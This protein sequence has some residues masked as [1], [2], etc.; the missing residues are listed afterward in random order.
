M[1]LRDRR[2]SLSVPSD[3]VAHMF[4]TDLRDA[5]AKAAVAAVGVLSDSELMAAMLDIETA[6]RHLDASRA[7][8]LHRLEATEATVT[9]Q[10]LRTASWVTHHRHQDARG[11]R[12]RVRASRHLCQHLPD[13]VEALAQAELSWDH[14]LVL[15]RAAN[16][17]IAGQVNELL[18]ELITLAQHLPFDIW[19]RE[20]AA[21]AEHLDADGAHQPVVPANRVRLTDGFD[22]SANLDGEF[23]DDAA[24]ELRALLD[25]QTDRIWRRYKQLSEVDGDANVIPPRNQ[26][27]AEALLE[28]VRLGSA[29]DA[30]ATRPTR[31]DVTVV[32]QPNG[33]ATTLSGSPLRSYHVEALLRRALFHAVHADGDGCVHGPSQ[34]IDSIDPNTEFGRVI[35]AALGEAEPTDLD[36]G[37]RFAN[38]AVRRAVASRDGGCVFP[39]CDLPIDW[40]DFHHVIAWRDGGPTTVGNTAPL[41]RFHHGVTHRLGWTM[42]ATTDQWFWWET[43]TGKILWSQRHHIPRPDPPPTPC[44]S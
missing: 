41:C 25:A 34:P 23:H 7:R 18:P 8:L 42:H 22:G 26:L 11:V 44:T 4:A 32:L 31:P 9:D 10:G 3:T 12:R 38:R 16:P 1:D 27:R 37:P 2:A 33:T 24:L 13:A 40:C 19:A 35:A 6:Q 14:C 17:R 28:L 30:A 36:R 15:Q 39:G 43:P 21:I 29:T 20:V 5:A